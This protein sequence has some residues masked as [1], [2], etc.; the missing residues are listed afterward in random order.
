MT[1]HG[2]M[3]PVWNCLVEEANHMSDIHTNTTTNLQ[4]T[5]K[6]K[7]RFFRKGFYHKVCNASVLEKIIYNNH[8]EKL[9]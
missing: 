9:Y 7:L 8:F 1:D 2:T 4:Q 5:N 3:K 6:E